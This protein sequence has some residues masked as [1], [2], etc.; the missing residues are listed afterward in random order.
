MLSECFLKELRNYKRKF[1]FVTATKIGENITNILKLLYFTINLHFVTSNQAFTDGK[2]NLPSTSSIYVAFLPLEMQKWL[3]Q[4]K[5][6]H[7]F[8]YFVWKETTYK[9]LQVPAAKT[10]FSSVYVIGA[11]CFDER[12]LFYVITGRHYSSWKI[13]VNLRFF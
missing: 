1:I 2:L 7:T 13:N 6:Y 10:L 11:T 4:I 5:I 9:P 3:Q 12:F 8:S